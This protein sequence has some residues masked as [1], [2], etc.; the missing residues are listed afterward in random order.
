MLSLVG[1]DRK[2]YAGWSEGPSRRICCVHAVETAFWLRMVR[3][4]AMSMVS[5]CG[6]AAVAAQGAEPRM[7]FCRKTFAHI[8]I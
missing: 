8:G 3:I 5:E 2:T 7:R 1:V 4:S 6:F